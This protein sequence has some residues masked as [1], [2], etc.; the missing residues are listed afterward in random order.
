MY[1]FKIRYPGIYDEAEKTA[2][3]DLD[4]ISK[5]LVARGK[6]DPQKL[7]AGCYAKDTP[8]IMEPAVISHELLAYYNEKYLPDE[9][10]YHDSAYARACGYDDIPALMTLAAY[11]H[12]LQIPV[13]PA[14]RDEF[15]ASNLWRKVTSVKPMYAGDTLWFTVDY[16]TWKDITPVQG[17]FYRTISIAS[18]GSIYNQNGELVSRMDMKWY[19]NLRTYEGKKPELKMPFIMVEWQNRPEHVYTDA[20]W[21][22][23]REI[24]KNEHRQ[25]C[26]P[27]YWDDVAVGDTPAWTLDG[28]FDDTP[29]PAEPWGPGAGGSRSLRR[30]YM[31]E[32]I[33]STMIR[34]P[35]DGIY[36]L[37]KR[38]MSYPDIPQELIANFSIGGG[39]GD[40][41]FA[42]SDDPSA[43]S[44]PRAIFINFLGRDVALRHIQN[45]MGDHGILRDI[46]WGIMNCACFKAIGYDFPEDPDI[47]DFLSVVPEMQNAVPTHG[48]ERDVMLVKSKVFDKCI[49]GKEHQ[50]KLAW[51]IE[52]IDGQL[53]ESGHATIVLPKRS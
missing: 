52:T 18:G 15:I 11:E 39:F 21:K 6:I 26:E 28:P 14:G 34:N 8:G 48:L 5:N 37:P 53:Y 40:L 3:E 7:V 23:M 45:W 38:S 1:T 33:F 43:P 36:R 51:W 46:S 16:M 50:V 20:D 12:M 19:E 27:R 31:D 13:P 49:V 22:F 41:S 4:S 42:S 29:N 30:D 44:G 9:P 35:Y 10:L 2:F 32:A 25:G 17:S 47:P 24:W